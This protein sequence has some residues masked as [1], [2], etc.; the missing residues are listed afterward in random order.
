MVACNM[1]LPDNP[2]MEPHLIS[3]NELTM[4]VDSDN[5]EEVNSYEGYERLP[6][7]QTNVE[8]SDDEDEDNDED[9]SNTESN[10]N[11][12]SITPVENNLVK[13]V[14]D[15]PSVTE[16]ELDKEKVDQVKAA[17]E[18]FTLPASSIPDWA[19]KIPEDQ[20]K[21]EILNRLRKN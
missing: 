19:N 15:G 4:P 11:L 3:N 12:P 18:N 2:E 13:E 5:E 7:E 17:L 20:W 6:M 16:I 9:G 8:S 10:C 1:G 14:W 21:N